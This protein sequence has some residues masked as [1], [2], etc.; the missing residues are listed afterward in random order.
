MEKF[1]KMCEEA[2]LD[3]EN[4]LKRLV[5]EWYCINNDGL[6]RFNSLLLVTFSPQN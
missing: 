2:N 1:K 4:Y 6:N 3:K 5:G